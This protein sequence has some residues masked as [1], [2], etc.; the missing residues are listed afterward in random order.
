MSTIVF[1][2]LMMAFQIFLP[3]FVLAEGI[4]DDKRDGSL[5]NRAPPNELMRTPKY[6]WG[7]YNQRFKGP[8]FNIDRRLCGP[9]VNHFCQGILRFNRSQNPMASKAERRQYLSQ[10]TG[11]FEYTMKGIEAYPQ[12]NIRKHVIMMQKRVRMAAMTPTP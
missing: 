4:Y 10:A 3:S 11:N 9:Y 6:C 5:Y 1:S 8:K 7:H 12:C 2:V